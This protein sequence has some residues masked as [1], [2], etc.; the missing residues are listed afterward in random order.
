MNNKKDEFDAKWR[1]RYVKLLILKKDFLQQM[2]AKRTKKEDATQEELNL[3]LVSYEIELHMIDHAIYYSVNT[4]EIGL[5]NSTW[6]NH[7]VN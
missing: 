7:D 2:I 5:N 1:E 6:G 4:N 3:E